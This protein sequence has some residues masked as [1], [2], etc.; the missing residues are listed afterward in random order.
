MRV[1]F[2]GLEGLEVCLD[3]SG[4]FRLKV[5]AT[6]FFLTFGQHASLIFLR[7]T[8]PKFLQTANYEKP[9]EKQK[10]VDKQ[11]LE[12]LYTTIS[13]HY[14]KTTV[15]VVGSLIRDVMAGTTM[16][17]LFGKALGE[18]V[19]KISRSSKKFARVS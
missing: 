15:D 13:K 11:L 10:K 5:S 12:R 3:G 9:E 8:L 19:I 6:D 17:G 16:D 4:N 1:K 7:W 2:E 18:K 14:P